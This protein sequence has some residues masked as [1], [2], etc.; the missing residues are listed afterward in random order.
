MDSKTFIELM[1]TA[2]GQEVADSFEKMINHYPSNIR[3]AVIGQLEALIA[4]TRST[5]SKKEN[6]IA[7]MVRN[8]SQTVTI[9]R[10][11]PEEGKEAEDG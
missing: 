11:Q 7:D 8:G 5:F 10:R 1:L 6:S 3:P 2:L 9:V 4:G